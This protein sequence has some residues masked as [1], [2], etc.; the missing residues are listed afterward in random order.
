RRSRSRSWRSPPSTILFGD[1][2]Q[3]SLFGGSFPGAAFVTR[4]H[5]AHGASPGCNRLDDIVV[6]GATAEIAFELVPDR[7]V[8][9]LVALAVHDVDGGHDHARRAIAALQ[10]MMLAECLLHGMQRAILRRQALDRG[11]LR[12]IDLPG[13]DGAGLDRL[14]I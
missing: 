5:G 2:F 12:A 7:L 10:A 1:P 4:T 3:R 11:D 9:E 13:K 14:A 6:T 8:V